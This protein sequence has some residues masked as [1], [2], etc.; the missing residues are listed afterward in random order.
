MCRKLF[1]NHLKIYLVI[2][3][4]SLYVSCVFLSSCF[5]ILQ[6]KSDPSDTGELEDILT[7]KNFEGLWPNSFHHTTVLLDILDSADALCEVLPLEVRLYYD[8]YNTYLLRKC[9]DMIFYQN[10]IQIQQRVSVI[11]FPYRIFF[12]AILKSP[13]CILKNIV[14]SLFAVTR[15]NIFFLKDEN[16][17]YWF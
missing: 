17:K 9:I 5:T 6:E 13:M 2:F 15:S 4:F 16:E 7:S 1:R 8:A 11:I 14:Y 3:F 12:L 10:T